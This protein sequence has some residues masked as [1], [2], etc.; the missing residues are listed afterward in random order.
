MTLALIGIIVVQGY[1]V[2]QTFDAKEDQFSSNARESLI[3]V[4]KQVETDEL[5]DYYGKF[6][7]LT[8]TV[9]VPDASKFSQLL[10]VGQDELTNETYILSNS[11]LQQDY[12]INSNIKGV[13]MDSVTFSEFQNTKVTL[14]RKEEMED[15]VGLSATDQFEKVSRLDDVEKQLLQDAI[16]DKTDRSPVYKRVDKE[17]LKRLIDKEL[18]IRGINSDYDFG[19]FSNDIVTKVSSADFDLNTKSAYGISIFPSERTNYKLYINF[20][21]KD[22]EIFS[23]IYLLFALTIVLTLIIIIAYGGTIWQYLNQRRISQIKTDFI[24]NMTHEFKTPIA[25]INLALDAL[26]NPK[27]SEDPKRVKNYT[28]MIRAENKRMHDQ[29]E[30]VL[31]ISKLERHELDVEKKRL[32]MHKLVE[33]AKNHVQLIVENRQGYIKTHF[34]AK[35]DTV[36]A[37][38][39]HFVSVLINILEN[40]IKYSDEAPKIDVFTENEENSII[41]KISDQGSGMSKAVQKRIFEKFYREPTGDIHNVKGHGLGLAYVKKIVEDHQGEIDVESEEGKGSIFK[42]KLPLIS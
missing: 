29:V 12:K 39:S 5:D 7:E 20:K 24:N 34:N 27:I 3:N 40:A 9:G 18:S 35:D 16:K 23:S 17:K 41:V 32:Y 30:N 8:D 14:V 4:A 26:G 33:E 2:K 11:I 13:E 28:R 36:L 19:V 22:K 10:H 38:Q 21:E 25:T 42:I 31:R 15:N 6:V 1:W 37:N